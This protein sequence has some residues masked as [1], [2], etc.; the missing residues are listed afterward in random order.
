[1]Q[2]LVANQVT[3]QQAI[4]QTTMQQETMQ[5]TT[6]QGIRNSGTMTVEF[7]YLKDFQRHNSPSFNGGQIDPIVAETWLGAMETTFFFMNCPL[8]Y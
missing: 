4:Q 3:M 2:T 5:Q 7:C 8:E 1:M 6:L